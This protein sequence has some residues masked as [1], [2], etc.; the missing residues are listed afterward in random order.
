[1]SAVVVRDLPPAL[2]QKLKAEAARHHR[3]M[4]R[5]IIAILEKEIGTTRTVALPPLVKPRVPVDGRWIADAIR[6]ARDSR[7]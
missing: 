3:S 6:K 4:N 1:M 5:E 2:H 7:P